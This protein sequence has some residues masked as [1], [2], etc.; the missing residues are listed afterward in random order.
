[1]R[2]TFSPALGEQTALKVAPIASGRPTAQSVLFKATFEDR[3]SLLEARAK[4]VRVEVWSNVPVAGRPSGEWGAFIFGPLRCETVPERTLNFSTE[5][6]T[7]E[8]EDDQERPLY[9]HVR[10][11]F[12]E[13]ID[14]RF[15]FTYRLVYP[16]G[17][18]K[19]LG[20]FGRNGELIIERGLPGVDLREGWSISD[21]G[22]YRTHAFPGERVLGH[23]TDPNAWTCWSWKS[24]GPPSFTRATE[25]SEGLAMVLSPRPYAR[26]VNVLRPLVFVASD[27]ASLRITDRGKI[28]LYSS[29]PFARVSFSVLEHAREL[30]DGV[31]ALS[32]GQVAVFDDATA[33]LTC[34]AVDAESPLHLV[35]LPMADNLDGRSVFPLRLSALP[36]PV[37]R[38]DSV[39]LSTPD[40]RIVTS[41][42]R[43]TS[44]QDSVVSVGAAGGHLVAAP[45]QEVVVDTRTVRVAFLTGHR[46]SKLK[47]ER[48]SLEALP[49]PPPSP[50]PP[51]APS[52][53]AAE[54]LPE[55]RTD[56]LSETIP[57][58][59]SRSPVE[60]DGAT[61]PRRSRSSA[62]IPHNSPHLIRR[63]LHMILDIV[64]WF[65]SVFAR[66]ISVRL[67]GES[68]TR[69]ISGFLGFALLKTAPPAVPKVADTDNA[70]T[71]SVVSSPQTEGPAVET[72]EHPVVAPS[73]EDVAA[74]QN[75]TVRLDQPNSLVV[76]SARI[77]ASSPATA[78]IY[79][80]GASRIEDLRVT[81][82]HTPVSSPSVVKL[83]DGAVLLKVG[84]AKAAGLLEVTFAM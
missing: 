54:T 8:P 17:E 41:V 77:P 12:H 55:S 59:R 79:V 40:L 2:L 33:I 62:L 56:A 19:W 4:G 10:A 36:E 71:E 66:T 46:E 48:S 29:S 31:A 34:R 6:A 67:I 52:R 75:D 9:V 11:P 78:V 24:P 45:A 25:P 26:E 51:S 50:P 43:A 39:V 47:A 5:D 83:S 30:L 58:S 16:S 42:M 65:W 13:H 68:N 57:L 82:D 20:E 21:D 76:I 14:G 38:W 27:S 44:E 70:R 74:V 53:L 60:R 73:V 49:T 18:I 7:E 81:V 69:R 84:D 23:L 35:V 32:G 80:Q 3:E 63:Y 1:M 15:Q 64:F 28:V 61:R 37:S 72:E 22:T